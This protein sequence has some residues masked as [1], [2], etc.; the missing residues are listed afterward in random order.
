MTERTRRE[1]LVDVGRGMLVAGVGTGLATDMGLAPAFAADVGDR[2]T[3]GPLEPLVGLMQDTP[4][5]QL[6]PLLV[7]RLQSGTAL[8]DLVAAGAFANA[9]AFGGE[10]Y[11]GYHTMMALAPAYHMARELPAE[12]QALPVLKVLYR[13]SS[14]IQDKKASHTD[15]LH[16]ILPAELPEGRS[17]ADVLHEAVL[18]KD[19]DAAE[20]TFAALAKRPPE[21]AFEDLLVTVQD[22]L[23]VHRV[24]LPHRAWSLLNIIGMEHAH[25]LLRQS[26]HYCIQNSSVQNMD[27]FAPARKQ[28]PELFDQYRLAGRARGSKPVDDAWIDRMSQTIFRST[29]E[30]AADAAAAALAE[31]I[32]P[33]AVGQAVTLAAN[34]LVLRDE[35]R[36]P[37]Q[38]SPG[39]PPGSVHG[40]S[41]GVHACDSANAWRQMAR[42]GSPRHGFAC[43][44]LA[45]WQ[46]PHDRVQ[47]GGKFLDWQPRPWAEHREAVK[48]QDPAAL[49]H[50]A[51]EAIRSND[52]ARACATVAKYGETGQSPRAVFDLLLR[53]AISEEGALHAEK[54]YRTVSEEFNSTRPAFR[55]RQ[56][57]ALARVTASE[58]G[59]PAAGYTDACRLLKV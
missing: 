33:D 21:Q 44:I 15:V 2:L 6:L 23:D 7:E 49:L 50:E 9:R 16:P 58:Y 29:S 45:A 26:V 28:L 53:Y 14:R 55:W 35:G 19:M 27:H 40:D 11:T 39:K 25:T 12:R 8:K 36:P 56:L 51:E 46:V 1:F 54:Y 13:N 31:G 24:V 48:A 57:I 20:R 32:D 17:G 52:Q 3:F 47:R 30:Q 43:L 38:T 42:V 5:A 59:Q 22:C 34:Q 4:P 10:D 41:I 18:R 37:N